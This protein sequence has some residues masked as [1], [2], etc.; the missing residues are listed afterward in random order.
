MEISLEK[1]TRKINER[2]NSL[3]I[4]VSVPKLKAQRIVEMYAWEHICCMLEES[5]HSNLKVFSCQ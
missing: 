1:N 3:F 4:F 2:R 5:Q